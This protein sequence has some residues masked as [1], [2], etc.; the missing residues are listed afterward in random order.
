[1]DIKEITTEI[2]NFQIE[3]IKLFECPYCN[4]D[5]LVT[6]WVNW[7]DKESQS[8]HKC[9]ECNKEFKIIVDMN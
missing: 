9:E 5:T 4:K 1:M 7:A 8:T 6:I 2:D 3:L